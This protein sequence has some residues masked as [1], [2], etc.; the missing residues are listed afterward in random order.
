MSPAKTR[1]ARPA[2][3]DPQAKLVVDMVTKAGTLE[4]WQLTPCA[5]RGL[6]DE[7]APAFDLSPVAIHRVEDR[8]VESTS[9]EIPVRVYT[10]SDAHVAWP[11][12]LWF[13]GGGHVVGSIDCCDAM[14]R[15]LAVAADCKVVSVGY[16]LAPE[17]KFPAAV[18]DSYGALGWLVRCADDLGVDR[19]RIAV[20]GDSAGG[21]L[22]A[23][24]SILARDAGMGAPRYQLLIYPATA[25]DEH[26]SSHHAYADGYLLNRRSILWFNRHYVRDDADR[27]DFRYAPL[28]ADDLSRL[29]PGLVIVAQCDPLRDEGVAYARCLQAAGNAVDL[30]E[31]PG[32]IHAFFSMSEVLDAGQEAV[33]LAVRSLRAAFA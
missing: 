15:H 2:A 4:Y 6:Y 14:C 24:V 19:S 10:P 20:G 9:A 8:T 30:V 32:M 31:F 13:H 3:L 1:G 11:A 28:L 23:V 27:R 12:L 33:A 16:R 29:P 17:H 22:A 7:H 25:A 26:S 18:E 5:A 21:N